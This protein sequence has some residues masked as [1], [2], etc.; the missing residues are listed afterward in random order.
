[1]SQY[2]LSERSLSRLEGVHPDLVDVVKRAI[3]ITE[4]D[5]GVSEGLRDIKTQEEYVRT[6]ASTTM[7]SR[8]LTGHAVDVFAYVDGK[9]QWAMP[10]YEKIASAFKQAAYENK[11]P[12]DWGG[13]WTSFKDGPHFQLSWGHYP[14]EIEGH[15]V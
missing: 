2:K 12:I 1:M 9:A 14:V 5:F 7:K 11:V 8:H 6:G 13:D 4:I 3:E 10:L 15:P